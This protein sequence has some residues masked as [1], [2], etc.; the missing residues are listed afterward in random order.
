MNT[1]NIFEFNGQ[2]T[3]IPPIIKRGVLIPFGNQREHTLTDVKVYN[4]G[5]Y[6][7]QFFTTV[8]DILIK[9]NEGEIILNCPLGEF[10]NANPN[11]KNIVDSKDLNG[12][13]FSNINWNES[14]LILNDQMTFD[15]T[16]PSYGDTENF[17]FKITISH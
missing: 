16:K 12:F 14:G 6:Y 9:N 13:Q 8:F 3:Q 1:V 17:Y 2:N 11:I 10:I 7:Y 15:I 4:S 5:L